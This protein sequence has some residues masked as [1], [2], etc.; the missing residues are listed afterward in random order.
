[1]TEI[2]FINLLGDEV[3]VLNSSKPAKIKCYLCGNDSENIGDFNYCG[4]RGFA[5]PDCLNN[6]RAKKEK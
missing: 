5:H 4:N 3:T 2:K 6:D 1:M